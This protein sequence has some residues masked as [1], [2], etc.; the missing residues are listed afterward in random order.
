MAILGQT[1][2]DVRG[3][4]FQRKVMK[5]RGPKVTSYQNE[6]EEKFANANLALYLYNF[7]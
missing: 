2:L 3:T 4:S 5:Y 6:K 1:I 7:L